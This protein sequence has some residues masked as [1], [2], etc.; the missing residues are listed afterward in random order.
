MRILVTAGN[1]QTPIDEVRC[2]TNI[3]TGRT[4]T[5][6]A[7]AAHARG[8]R[9]TLLTSH[10][11]VVGELTPAHTPEPGTWEI[12][13]YRTYDDLHRL[14]AAYIPNGQFDAVIHSAAVSD[15]NV[16]GIY[17][18]SA[19]STFDEA[20]GKWRGDATMLDANAPKVK[21]SHEELWLRLTP[22]EKLIDKIRHPW[23]FTGTLVKFKLEVGIG[24]TELLEIAERS[25]R[26]SHA[27]WMV[28]NTLDMIRDAAYV[29]RAETGYER[30]Q[31]DE[32]A[33][34]LLDRIEG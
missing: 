30:V 15:Y 16:T 25:R 31:R 6:V 29:G 10:P 33:N 4:G 14:M 9:V 17:T 8:H 21:S 24:E 26:H 5:R 13:P 3:F 20:S 2:I 1:T 28:A 19:N 32:L 7:L 27:D 12:V 22:T 18:T 34:R 11:G 23:G